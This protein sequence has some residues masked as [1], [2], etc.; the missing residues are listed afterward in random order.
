ERSQTSPMSNTAATRI[1]AKGQKMAYSY[2]SYGRP[3]QI[4]HYPNGTTED[5]TQQVNLYYDSYSGAGPNIVGRLAA[6][7][8]GHVREVYGYTPAGELSSKVSSILR[9]G[10][11]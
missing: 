11:L 9:L 5:T 2:D 3:T 7:T 6:A 1:D 4:R 10:P 8:N